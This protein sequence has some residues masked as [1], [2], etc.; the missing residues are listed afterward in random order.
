VLYCY[1]YTVKIYNNSLTDVPVQS[2]QCLIELS[3]VL[4]DGINFTT[5]QDALDHAIAIVNSK[6][7]LFNSTRYSDSLIKDVVCLVSRTSWT[8]N[9]F[10]VHALA[11][12]YNL[13]IVTKKTIKSSLHKFADSDD[14]LKQVFLVRKKIMFFISWCVERKEQLKSLLPLLRGLLH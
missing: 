3:G 2:A 7:H 13:L 14:L 12:A 4:G 6:P 5:V 9:M 1:V 11:D 8:G 10:A